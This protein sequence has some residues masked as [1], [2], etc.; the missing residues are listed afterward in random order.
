MDCCK[1]EENC[2][3]CKNRIKCLQAQIDQLQ[4]EHDDLVRALKLLLRYIKIDDDND[5]VLLT[6]SGIYVKGKQIL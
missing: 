4:E 6:L 1:K 3:S 5:E 2:C